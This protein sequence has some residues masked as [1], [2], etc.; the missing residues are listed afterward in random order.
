MEDIR[1]QLM[2]WISQQLIPVGVPVYSVVPDDTNFPYIF[3]GN[4]STEE[5]QNKTNFRQQGFVNVEIYFS[6]G[7]SILDGLNLLKEVKA[8]LQ[9]N[10]G[11]Y[12]PFFSSWWLSSDSGFQA[13]NAGNR[14]YVATIQYRFEY[15]Q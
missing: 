7:Y 15:Q 10:K 12:P 3:I 2:E 5:L 9:P 8:L 1:I 11:F 13:I 4:V 6:A 14:V